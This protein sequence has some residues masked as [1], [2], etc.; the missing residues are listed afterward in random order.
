MISLAA[1]SSRIE[2]TI[3][4]KILIL[5]FALTFKIAFNWVLNIFGAS[6]A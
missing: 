6:K 5:A 2:L 1:L 4:N 3:G